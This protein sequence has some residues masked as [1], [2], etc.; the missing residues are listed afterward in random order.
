[1]KFD[2][3]IGNPPYHYETGRRKI[4]IYNKFIMELTGEHPISDKVCL[5]TPDGFVK[6]GLN[7]EP[8]RRHMIESKHLQAVEFHQ[9][10]LFHNAEVNAAITLFD[11]DCQFDEIKKTIVHEDNQ[12]ETG[13]LDW[14][15]RDVIIDELKYDVLRLFENKVK[16]DNNMSLP[17]R[18]YFAII[19]KSFKQNRNKFYI[20]RERDQSSLSA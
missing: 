7:L 5:I 13:I 8:C 12:Q 17:P 18:G 10:N 2:I 6:G 16:R 11:N 15:Y 20:E 9:D 1:M 19:T 3:A 4:P 14:Y